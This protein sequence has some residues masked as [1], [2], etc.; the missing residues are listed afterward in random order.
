MDGEDSEEDG[1]GL[2]SP[3]ELTTASVNLFH[4]MVTT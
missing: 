3:N 1:W 2:P 4:V